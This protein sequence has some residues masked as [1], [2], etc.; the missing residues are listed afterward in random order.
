VNHI[1]GSKAG[2]AGVYN[3]AQYLPEKREALEKWGSYLAGQAAL[4][5]PASQH[6]V[7]E[8]SDEISSQVV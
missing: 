3:R 6:Q 2:V 5:V 7:A 1:S 4:A 8:Q